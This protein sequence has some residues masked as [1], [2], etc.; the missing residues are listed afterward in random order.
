MMIVRVKINSFHD[1][2]LAGMKWISPI[3]LGDARVAVEMAQKLFDEGIYVVAFSYP[4][5]PMEKAR[6]RVQISAAHSEEDIRYAIEAFAKV[7]ASIS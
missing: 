2:Q 5:V 1:Y 4:V 3:I 7:Y 6:V